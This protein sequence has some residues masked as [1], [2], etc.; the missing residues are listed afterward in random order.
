MPSTTHYDDGN[1]V[2]D[3]EGLTLR[4]YYFPSMRS[5]HI[6]YRDIRKVESF[7]MGLLSGKTRAWGTARTNTWMPLDTGRSRK[8][9]AILV[10]VGAPIRPV[11][12]PDD[13]QRVLELLRTL[14]S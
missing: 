8:Q 5:K 2:L 4:R 11:F 6:P 3:D 13:P 10:D 7:K 9:T 1:V 14:A 12:T